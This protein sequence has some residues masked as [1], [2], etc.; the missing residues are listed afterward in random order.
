LQ[1]RSYG[2]LI[3]YPSD[4]RQEAVAAVQRVFGRE[5]ARIDASLQAHRNVLVCCPKASVGS[6][7]K[8]LRPAPWRLAARHA[9][10][11]QGAL[12]PSLA[13]YLAE[14]LADAVGGEQAGEAVVVIPHL[15]LLITNVSEQPR[16]EAADVIYWLSEYPAVTKLAFYD[17]AFKLPKLV[18]DF[19]PT[20]AALQTFDRENTWALFSAEEARKFCPDDTQFTVAS[21]LQ[22]YH[23]LSGTNVGEIRRILRGLG[24]LPANPKD[25]RTVQKAF[26]L[27]RN[28]TAAQPLVEEPRIAGYAKL[29]DDL[30]MN[31]IEP[32]RRRYTAQTELELARYDALVPRGLL[33]F[34]RPGVGKTE[35]MKFLAWKLEATLF[36]VHGPELKGRY[37]GDTEA[38]IRRLF[39]NARHAAPSMIAI[40]EAEALFP[41]RGAD[42]ATHEASMV[43]QFLTEMQGLRRS[44]SVI[45][46]AST[47]YPERI[48]EAFRRPGRFH[49][50]EVPYPSDADREAILLYYSEIFQ[51]GL[52]EGSIKEL[53]RVTG[54]PLDPQRDAE[55]EQYLRAHV[56]H[57]VDA[58][59]ARDAGPELQ[60]QIR[61][62]LGMP[63]A[64][65]RFSGDHLR[66]I[67][68]KLLGSAL[69]RNRDVNDSAVLEEAVKAVRKPRGEEPVLAN[70]GVAGG[71]F[72]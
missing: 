7:L 33:L 9:G 17:P 10:E 63:L 12:I 54:G 34:G 31:V 47:N 57:T 22:L 23:Y 19:F 72:S 14:Q 39:D 56:K 49:L 62:Q 38:A 26:D 50:I 35:W 21:Q 24:P 1:D 41:A 45:V 25:A 27:L 30:E 3:A 58:D 18:E 37:V 70:P 59:L 16:S 52:N 60:R 68:L 61:M 55:L 65:A 8:A 28:Q 48:D 6:V 67:A 66:A 69:L 32:L 2:A 51:I 53:V 40:D 43:G 13:Q 64:P 11:V 42:T 44:E 36:L 4:L 5:I 46:V 15:D 71:R 29:R 20:K